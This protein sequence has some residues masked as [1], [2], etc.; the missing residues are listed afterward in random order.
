MIEI[1]SIKKTKIQLS[2][3]NYEDD[4]RHRLFFSRITKKELEVLEEILFSPLQFS[5]SELARNLEIRKEEAEQILNEFVVLGL[6]RIDQDTIFVNKELRKLFDLEI[7]KF[8]D[9]F[10]PGID[11]IQAILKK[12]PIQVLPNW[13]QIP[14]S[15]NN[16]FESLIERIF[17]T[18]Q[19]YQRH[20]YEVK[21][22]TQ[23]AASIFEDLFASDTLSL[24][25]DQI[26][27]T[28]HLDEKELH[29][30]ILEFEF[31]FIGYLTYELNEDRFVEILTP[32][33]EWKEFTLFNKEK[34][35]KSIPSK[36]I[37][38][39]RPD[40][41]AFIQDIQTVLHFCEHQPIELSE[42]LTINPTI[43]PQLIKL[44]KLNSDPL[45][46]QENTLY[47][48]QLIQKSL[49]L[50]LAKNEKNRLLP[51]SFFSDWSRQ[52]VEKQA[53]YIYKHPNNRFLNPGCPS[54]LISEK[55]IREL[56]KSLTK[57]ANCSWV[58]FDDFL[59]GC[60]AALGE[61]NRIELKK[62]GKTWK[63]ALPD[64]S[65]KEK[66]FIQIALLEWLFESGIVQ[67]GLH[68]LK[69]CFRL[70]SLGK[71]LFTSS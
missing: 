8:D 68:Q 21:P 35:L 47:V 59:E 10:V 4:I 46:N 1:H 38:M 25:I 49:F 7:Q 36:K 66:L 63:Y 43:T 31:N 6:I 69:P 51:T 11:Y 29:E 5:L 15:S 27:K 41:Y 62:F 56:E 44:L 28:Y 12:V 3:Y 45:S 9:R 53:L 55:N 48:R 37:E 33:Q 50:D 61:N 58:Y 26:K 13:Y 16:I 17:I 60:L 70:T 34:N 65:E 2:D 18:P 32:F 19:L 64:Y 71:K 52:E 40:E 20:L 30:L 23:P 54:D 22:T 57:V 24:P 42:T 14:R 67:T 39:F